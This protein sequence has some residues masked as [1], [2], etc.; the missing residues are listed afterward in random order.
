[1]QVLSDGRE[2]PKTAGANSV[3]EVDGDMH[4]DSPVGVMSL[5][6]FPGTTLSAHD[7]SP[8]A[9]SITWA[10]V[11]CKTRRIPIARDCARDSVTET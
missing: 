1:M 7:C 11:H 4:S 6:A 3:R 9:T 2:A 8:I 10:L 5:Q